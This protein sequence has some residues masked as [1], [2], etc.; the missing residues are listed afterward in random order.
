MATAP[1]SLQNSSE[2]QSPA[3]GR[4][5]STGNVENTLSFNLQIT[6]RETKSNA[7]IGLYPQRKESLLWTLKS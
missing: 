3:E 7:I 2:G 6:S 5:L 4:L 1:R